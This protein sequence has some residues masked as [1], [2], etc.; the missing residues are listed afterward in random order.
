MVGVGG[1]KRSSM[2]ILGDTTESQL[3]F[4]LLKSGTYKLTH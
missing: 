2:W 1:G 4:Q 3:C